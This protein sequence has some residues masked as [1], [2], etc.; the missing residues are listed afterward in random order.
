MVLNSEIIVS[1]YDGV[2]NHEFNWLLLHY[3][4][5]SPDDLELYSYG[6]EG[7]EQLKDNIYDLEQIF[8]AFYRQEVDGNPGYILIAYIPPSALD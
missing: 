8:V 2:V 7:L 5:E 3:A 4:S 1:A 6:S